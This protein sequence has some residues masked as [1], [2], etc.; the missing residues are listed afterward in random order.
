MMLAD[1]EVLGEGVVAAGA[2]LVQLL[3]GAGSAHHSCHC[4]HV[5]A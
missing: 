2:D 3:A 5:T 4:R 1:T